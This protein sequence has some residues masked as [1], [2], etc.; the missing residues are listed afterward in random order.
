M[1]TVQTFVTQIP[2]SNTKRTK[3]SGRVN[4]FV[5]FLSECHINKTQFLTNRGHGEDGRTVTF[6]NKK[7]IETYRFA[8]FPRLQILTF[9]ANPE[10]QHFPRGVLILGTVV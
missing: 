4:T 2:M 7:V 6:I 5:V 1:L 10:P 9:H 8:N 3:R